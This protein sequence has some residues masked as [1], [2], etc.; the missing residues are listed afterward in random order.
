MPETKLKTYISLALKLSGKRLL[1]TTQLKCGQS[2]WQMAK[3]HLPQFWIESQFVSNRSSR[4]LEIKKK[5]LHPRPLNRVEQHLKC[6][7]RLR[8]MLHAEAEHHD[9]ALAA[10]EAYGCGFAFKALSAV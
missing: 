1:I 10:L 9:L 5:L 7:F 4:S 3:Y 8:A 2:L 6:S